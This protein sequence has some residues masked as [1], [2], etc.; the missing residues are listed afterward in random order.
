MN[1]K[2]IYD[3]FS[4]SIDQLSW[5]TASSFYMSE[6]YNKN[7]EGDAGEYPKIF[8]SV[9]LSSSHTDRLSTYNLFLTIVDVYGMTYSTVQQETNK[10]VEIIDKCEI[11]WT[12]LW[13]I[14]KNTEG[15]GGPDNVNIVTI[16]EEG[17]D[18]YSGIEVNFTITIGNNLCERFPIIP[19]PEPEI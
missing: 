7:D 6:P 16:H 18:R 3:L 10:Q 1:T 4:T 12:Q 8:L 14:L 13:N 17:L 9:P 2:R 11:I 19:E 5:V 15:V